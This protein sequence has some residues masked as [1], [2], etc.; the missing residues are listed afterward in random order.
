MS[1]IPSRN[2][3]GRGHPMTAGAFNGLSFEES[4]QQDYVHIAMECIEELSRREQRLLEKALEG[5]TMTEFAHSCA[6][7]IMIDEPLTVRD[8]MASEHEDEWRA[9]M[10]KEIEM[11]TEVKCFE[12]LTEKHALRRGKLVKS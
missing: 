3:N 10:K 9:A 7:R 11:L 1:S 4:I 8:A 2:A 6:A 12:I 5:Q